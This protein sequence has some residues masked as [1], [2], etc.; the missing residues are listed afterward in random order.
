MKKYFL[1]LFF[2]VLSAFIAKADGPPVE[3][4]GTITSEHLSIKLVPDQIK[5][6]EKSHIIDL[7]A[8]QHSLLKKVYKNF[9]KR[10]VVVTPHYNDCTCDLVYLIWNK[11]DTVALPLDSVNYFKGLLQDNSYDYQGLIR[12]WNKQKIIV[13]TKG[14]LYNESK[15]INKTALEELFKKLSNDKDEFARWISISLPPYLKTQYEK[16]IDAVIKE[17]EGVADKYKVKTEV[18]G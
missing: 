1:A 13:D 4:D 5:Q 6:I 12:N 7:K 11:I 9:P 14:N 2:I 18:G 15:N 17:I 16:K 8:G 10:F 3:K